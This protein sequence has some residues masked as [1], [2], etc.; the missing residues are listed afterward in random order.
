[1]AYRID[2]FVTFSRKV[3]CGGHCYSGGFAEIPGCQRMEFR[4]P[5]AWLRKGT[6]HIALAMCAP[7]AFAP[8]LSS[9]NVTLALH[10]RPLSFS[11]IDTSI[12]AHASSPLWPLVQLPHLAQASQ[13]PAR[14][15]AAVRPV[16]GT[17]GPHA[18]YH[19]RPPA[20]TPRQS[21]FVPSGGAPI[22]V[23]GVPRW[24]QATDRAAWVSTRPRC[25]RLARRSIAPCQP[26][27]ARA[28]HRYANAHRYQALHQGPGARCAGHAGTWN[29]M[30]P[31][32][33]AGCM[34]KA[35]R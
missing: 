30:E 4:P 32:T 9:S 3:T 11:L 34:T 15:R 26:A 19:R 27:K 24:P 21:R 20:P 16:P 14:S 12:G 22:P 2:V 5:S 6:S 8:F 7:G 33:T 28:S 25:R 23:Q 18:R 35:N 31:L 13:A 10:L 17:Q 29:H 1:M